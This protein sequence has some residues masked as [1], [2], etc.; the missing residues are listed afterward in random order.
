M[1]VPLIAER[2]IAEDGEQLIDIWRNSARERVSPPVLPYCFSQDGLNGGFVTEERVPVRPLSSLKTEEWWRYSFRNVTG[3]SEASRNARPLTTAD[4]HV[5][6]VERLLVDFPDFYR[7]FA[8][9]DELKMLFLDIEQYTEGRG[10]PTYKDPMISIAWAVNDSPVECALATSKDDRDVLKRFLE[11]FR[12]LDPDVIVGYNVQAYDL[13]TIFRRMHYHGIDWRA[14]SRDSSQPRLGEDVYVPGRAI[15]DVYDSVKYDQTLYGIKGRRLKDVGEWMGFDVIREDTSNTAALLGSER[16]AA[17]NISDVELTRKLTNVYFRNFLELADFYGAPLNLI[18]RSTPNIHTNILQGRV[19]ARLSPRIVSDG[20][21]DERFP[22]FYGS[23]SEKAFEAAVVDIYKR[24]RFEPLHKLDFSSMFPSIMVSLGA[25]SDNTRI[26]GTEP[27]GA[28]SVEKRGTTRIYHI[29]DKTRDWNVLVS[30]EGRSMTAEEVEKLIKRR[31]EL[32]R[33]SKETTDARVRDRL[34]ARQSAMKIILNSIYGVMGSR[35]ARYGSL[36]V[37]IA[38]VGVGRQLIRFVEAYLGDSKIETDTD[39]VYCDR[40]VDLDDLNRRLETYVRNELGAEF[41][42]GI[43]QDSYRSGYFHEKKSYLL[44]LKDGRL[45]KHGVAFK[46]SSLCGVFDKTLDRIAQSLLSGDGRE[47]DVAKSCLDLES[48]APADFVMR[49]R[50]GKEADD[51]KS[52]NALGAQLGRA[53][54]TL[55]GRDPLVGESVEYVKTK[56]GFDIVSENALGCLDMQYYKAQV[57]SIA[58]RLGIRLKPSQAS[59]AAWTPS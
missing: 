56:D 14:M 46:G 3:I 37:A 45:E 33:E 19:F 18:L 23:A 22:A 13:T 50:F 44:L 20:R 59:L 31:L 6:F 4:D 5:A 30:I 58:E 34:N 12:R 24:G 15:Y 48:Y 28:F 39:G 36:P 35:H 25:G 11:A 47:R 57:E 1:D 51:Y 41:K 26:I 38:I 29:P 8:N 27:Y 21:N 40:A 49:L 32:K 9:S 2:Y 16:L 10:F 42:L 52:D 7:G 43:E 55:H 54:K 53:F 17:Y